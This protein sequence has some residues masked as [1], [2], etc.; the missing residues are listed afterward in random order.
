M[1]NRYSLLAE[2]IILVVTMVPSSLI[3]QPEHSITPY[4]GLLKLSNYDGVDP[5]SH[6][7][8]G[9]AYL[10]GARVSKDITTNNRLSLSYGFTSPDHFANFIV[11]N[12]NQQLTQGARYRSTLKTHVLKIELS[13][14]L[15]TI[16]NIPL[17]GN[18]GGGII[19]LDPT[20]NSLIPP[21]SEDA[22]QIEE[23]PTVIDPVLSLG[24]GVRV[25]I[26]E[27]GLLLNAVESFQFC[28]QEGPQDFERDYLCASQQ[29]LDHPEITVG[30]EIVL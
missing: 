25:P 21:G 20:D 18:L 16:G 9:R 15:I 3:A 17:L 2:C 5:Y 12:G 24:I 29:I 19:V 4:V 27:N 7:V 13:R 22:V 26:G 1:I 14:R 28:Q 10:I 11:R 23:F 8:I 30:F 6:F